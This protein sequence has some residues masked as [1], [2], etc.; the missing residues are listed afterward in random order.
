MIDEPVPADAPVMAPVLVPRVQAK[1]LEAEAVR[2][3]LGLV[4]LHVLAVLAVV[5]P[6]IGLTVTVILVAEPRQ[7]PTVEVGVTLYTIL[8]A[9]ALLGL[10]NV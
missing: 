2:L 8:P 9:L 4:P 6:G 5:L 7:E 1:E 10:V 3:I